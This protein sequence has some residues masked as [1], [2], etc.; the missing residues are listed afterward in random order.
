MNKLLTTVLII[1][2][3]IIILCGAILIF[4]NIFK[5]VNEYLSDLSDFISYLGMLFAAIALLIAALA[6]KSA[7]LNPNLKLNLYTHMNEKDGPALLLD[8]KTNI[9]SDCKPLTEWYFILD[10]IGKVAAKYPVVQINFNGAYFKE[11]DFPG[12]KSIHHANA[13]GWFGFQWSPT[14]NEIVYPG[15]SM[16]LPTMYFS[17]KQIDEVPLNIT[18][19]I[20][21]DRFEKKILKFPVKIEWEDS[22]I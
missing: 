13:L 12:W 2:I 7:N 15:I 11:D 17:G 5:C 8:K 1:S 14:E 20:A 6:Y 10:N 22:D 3:L 18:I 9:V 16:Q 21:A 19:I 4:P